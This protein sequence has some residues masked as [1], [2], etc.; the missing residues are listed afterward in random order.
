MTGSGLF[1]YRRLASPLHAA[2]AGAGACWVLALT[3]AAVLLFNPLAL[4]SLLALTAGSSLLPLGTFNLVSNLAIA[5]FKA[6]LVLY[7]F[8]RIGK[9]RPIVRIAAAAGIVWLALLCALALS[10]VLFRT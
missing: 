1:I 4:L 10:D 8:M 2:R 9:S 7:F 3:A 5:V 6:A